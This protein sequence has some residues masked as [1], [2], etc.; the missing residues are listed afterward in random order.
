M[1]TITVM[2]TC[3]VYK[4]DKAESD[5]LSWDGRLIFKDKYAGLVSDATNGLVLYY[6]PRVSRNGGVYFG[7][8]MVGTV[9]RHPTL[10]GYWFAYTW[11]F[12]KLDRDV[13]L[14]EDGKIHES[15]FNDRNARSITMRR[16]RQIPEEELDAIVED[17]VSAMAPHTSSNGMQEPLAHAYSPPDAPGLIQYESVK[18]IRRA[19][20]RAHA[21]R[22][23][24]GKCCISSVDQPLGAGIV[25]AECCHF[26]PLE[27]RG[28]DIIQNTMLMGRSL[29]AVFDHGLIALDDDFRILVKDEL[30]PKYRNILNKDGFA[31]M[32]LEPGLR[33]SIEFIRYHRCHIFGAAY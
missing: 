15:S 8:A 12:R 31:R 29:H 26:W 30:H 13:S 32:P 11:G 17:S 21:L 16:V 9:H 33:P 14:I 6:R 20:L 25:E 19:R 23:Y 28:P 4:V 7:L 1:M 27:E 2:G 10:D 18:R 5:V 24:G 22:I 3:I